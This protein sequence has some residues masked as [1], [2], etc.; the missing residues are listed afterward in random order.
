MLIPRN[1]ETASTAE[2]NYKATKKNLLRKQLLELS[3]EIDLA[4]K[5]EESTTTLDTE[6]STLKAEYDAIVI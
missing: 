1:S 6:F 4:A 3:N 2:T 5:M